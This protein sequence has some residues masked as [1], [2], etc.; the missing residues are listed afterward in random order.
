[1]IEIKGFEEFQ[2]VTVTLRDLV[3]VGFD[4]TTMIIGENFVENFDPKKPKFGRLVKKLRNDIEEEIRSGSPIYD[5]E[6]AFD[7]S[8]SDFAEE[9]CDFC[10]SFIIKDG[11][12]NI[13]SSDKRVSALFRNCWGMFKNRAIYL[14]RPGR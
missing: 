13:R 10:S 5:V 4:R 7:M 3:S 6:V 1:M 14:S 2:E 8:S 12:S 9:I 11:L